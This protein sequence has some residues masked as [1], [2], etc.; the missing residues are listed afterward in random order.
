[1]TESAKKIKIIIAGGGTGGHVFPALVIGNELMKRGAEVLFIGTK[2]GLESELVPKN[3]W[4]I[5]YLFAPRWKGQGQLRKIFVLLSLPFVILKAVVFMIKTRPDVVVG[6]GGYASF[7]AVFAAAILWIPT[8]LMEQ[9]S[10]PGV[11]NRILA[12]V[13]KK[14][15]VTFPEMESY[16]P[17]KK[18]M[19]TG[20]PV[21]EEIRQVSREIP[22]VTGK[23][24]VMCFGGSQGAKSLNEAVFASLRF[25]RNR[26]DGIKFI[27]QIGT[28]ADIDIARDIYTKEGFEAEVYRFIDDIAD[29]YAR[30]HLVICRAGATSISELIATC[31]P[32]VLVPYPFS[33]NAHQDANAEFVKK[34]GAAIVI[35]DADL[36]GDRV[37]E[38]IAGF[39]RDPARL[40][41]MNDALKQLKGG[42]AA[43]VIADEI[44]RM[45]V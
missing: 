25:L 45:A 41:S 15:C 27:H 20:N 32:A 23:F 42:D 19:W 22:P 28:N 4:K 1:M 34:A 6:V 5:E 44:L 35:K 14:I 33:A 26:K 38:L 9:N 17:K 21:R 31:R 11:A 16:F 36:T 13:T 43:T 37:A 24:I 7:P 30:A 8:L 29:C 3:G 18:T 2:K 10:I 40:Q 39:V 12:K